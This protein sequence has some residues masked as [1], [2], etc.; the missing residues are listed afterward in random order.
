MN[1]SVSLYF[2]VKSCVIM[3]FL[4]KKALPVCLRPA[5]SKEGRAGVFIDGSVM[6]FYRSALDR[7]GLVV[8]VRGGVL[9]LPH[10]LLLLAIYRSAV[11]EA[12]DYIGMLGS[13]K[14]L[15]VSPPLRFVAPLPRR[16]KALL[17]LAPCLGG[18]FR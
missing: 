4:E 1:Q 16:S 15:R 9:L 13:G 11:H 5:L 10:D 8:G 7:I 12:V 6:V 2:W 18:I 3:G 17:C 14:W